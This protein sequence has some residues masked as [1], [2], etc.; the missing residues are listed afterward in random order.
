[1]EDGNIV[2]SFGSK[3]NKS[4]YQKS[5]LS[6]LIQIALCNSPG[7]GGVAGGTP[8]FKWQEWSNGAK[9]QKPQKI[10]RPKLTPQKSY[11]E[12]LSLKNLKTGKQVWLYFN[13]GTMWPGYAGTITN[14]QIVLYSQKH[15]YL[16]Q[17][18]QKNTCQIFLPKKNIGIKNFKPRKILQSS[19]SLE[20]RST[21]PWV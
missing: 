18:I 10:P 13:H 2:F 1:M 7:E 4:C 8:D 16:N 20:I 3:N 9:N 21:P 6:K 17:A 15:P 19:L 5:L 12:F 11:A 14:L